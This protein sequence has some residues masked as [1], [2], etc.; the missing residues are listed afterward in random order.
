[1]AL[2]NGFCVVHVERSTELGGEMIIAR[3]RKADA[4]V[5]D[6]KRRRAEWLAMLP[7][8][9]QALP[10]ERLAA[11]CPYEAA[12]LRRGFSDERLTID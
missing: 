9:V 11:I 2:Q 8:E 10:A 5:A 6:C 12:E 7:A 1:M 3:F 4:A